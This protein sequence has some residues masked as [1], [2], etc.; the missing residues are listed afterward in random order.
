MIKL[1]V[2][3]MDG[4]LFNSNQEISP[5]NLAAIREARKQDVRFMIATGRS[6]DTITPTTEKYNL[7]CGLILLNG[8]EVRDEEGH[9]L[10][11]VNIDWEIIPGL[12]E[13]LTGQGYV[14]EYM[15]NKGSQ[16]CGTAEMM[17][18]NMGFR[19]M[20]L[21]RSHTLSFEEAV[22]QGRNSVFQQSLTR[23]DTLEDMLARD[24][25]I[26]KIIV[27]N[28]DREFNAKN[29]EELMEKFPELS[30]LSSYPENIEINNKYAQKG[31]GLL[32]AIEKMGIGKEEVAVFGDGLN[33]LSM[34][35]L[36]PNSYAPE[37]AEP[38]IRKRAKEIIPSNNDDGV[39]K[40]INELLYQN[41]K[42]LL[43]KQ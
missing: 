35:E 8:A 29:R 38:E 3:D 33:D 7:H 39:G 15:T 4:T 13:M 23:N 32:E 27:F 36:F 10:N 20:C 6:V 22:E 31:Y 1:L 26:R 37:N 16:L 41:K 5:F 18:K 9:I 43:N 30:I 11:T 2:S 40:K 19:M 14:P 21:D 12:A 25:E 42:E 24:L 28:P 17:E 34:F